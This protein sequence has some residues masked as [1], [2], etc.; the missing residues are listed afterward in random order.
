ML[1]RRRFLKAVAAVGAV[2]AV[3]WSYLTRTP[4]ARAVA[5]ATA[6]PLDPASVTKYAAPLIIP[7]AMPGRRPRR[8]VCGR[9]HEIAI[10]RSPADPA[11][12]PARDDGLG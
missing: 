2:L 7:P 12:R 9:L 4:A 5:A 10:R 1:S 8:A 11:T 6:V 3:P